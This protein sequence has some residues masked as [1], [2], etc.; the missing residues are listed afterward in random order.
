MSNIKPDFNRALIR[1]F[2][3]IYDNLGIILLVNTL[4]LILSATIILIPAATASMF[5]ICRLIIYSKPVKIK[6]FFSAITKFFINST[7][8]TIIFLLLYFVLLFSI[9]FY[10]HSLG[11][12][13]LF[14][15][16]ICFWLFA[17]SLLSSLYAFLLLTS[18][19]NLRKTLFYGYIFVLDNTKTTL[20]IFIFILIML[21]LE[22][23]LPIFGMGILVVFMQN[24]FLEI[25]KKYNPE[26]I[27]SLPGRKMKE[28]W[29]LSGNFS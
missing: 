25:E 7:A 16:G 14:L 12:A 18:G 20:K 1:T 6:D 13:G 8:L 26:V 2:W 21:L 27:I 5:Y 17:L 22:I 4:W 23:L 9:K 24:I 15:S 28:L 19:R 11:I 29:N 3:Q 10:I